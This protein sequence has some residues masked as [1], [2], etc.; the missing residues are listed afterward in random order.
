MVSYVFMADGTQKHFDGL[1]VG[2]VLEGGG[3][4]ESLEP[5]FKVSNN[6]LHLFRQISPFD[7]HHFQHERIQLSRHP[8]VVVYMEN[9]YNQPFFQP[10]LTYN[11]NT[12]A[13]LLAAIHQHLDE[14]VGISHAEYFPDIQIFNKR[15]GVA[16]RQRIG[17]VLPIGC[18]VVY[19]LLW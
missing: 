8:R 6:T 3:T 19:V 2:D 11:G 15:Q 4:V 14:L 18:E 1:L 12:H 16:G 7:P 17:S 10:F 9:L 13:G 5:V